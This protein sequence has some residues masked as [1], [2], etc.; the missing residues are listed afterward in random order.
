[1]DMLDVGCGPA[2]ITCDLATRV[3]S[4]IGIEPV[5]GDKRSSFVE[6][7]RQP[8]PP[9][10]GLRGLNGPPERDAM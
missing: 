5:E 9:A 4:I 8:P 7:A 10:H 6:L 2:T 1:M 3:S